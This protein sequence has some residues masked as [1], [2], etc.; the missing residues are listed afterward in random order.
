MDC[1]KESLQNL[2]RVRFL[3]VV[4]LKDRL[5]KSIVDA[6]K[7]V[8]RKGRKPSSMRFDKCSEFKNR[9]IKTYL[10]NENVNVYFTKNPTKANYAERVIKTLKNII[11][12]YFTAKQSYIYIYI[13]MLYHIWYQITITIHTDHW[14]D[15]H[16]PAPTRATKTKY[17]ISCTFQ[18]N[19]KKNKNQTEKE[20]TL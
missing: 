11:Y 3:W 19:K 12:R 14:V 9:W 17:D 18:R 4:P 7:S 6:I 8:F 20:I 2:K 10:S 15:L 5:G 13:Y 1:K 16:P